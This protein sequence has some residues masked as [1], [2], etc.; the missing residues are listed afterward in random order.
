MQQARRSNP[1][2]WTW[3][4]AAA[5]GLLVLLE[6]VL[7]I[8]LGRSLA[9]LTAGHGWHWIA[10]NELFRSL[11]G[12]L[13][14]HPETGLP[15]VSAHA[16]D[17]TA[18]TVWIGVTLVL[19]LAATAVAGRWAWGRWG[20]SRML[21]MA[22][23]E[24]AQTVLGMTRLHKNRHIIRPDLYPKKSRHTLLKKGA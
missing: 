17:P 21:G 13:T 3:E 12:V 24:E 22:T 18:M 1:Y 4:P 8:H 10:N 14:G 7:G 5:L 11:P 16:A 15:G 9:I 23:R 19:L 2:P 6:S 20:T